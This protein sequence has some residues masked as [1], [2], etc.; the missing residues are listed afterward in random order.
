[1]PPRHP[2]GYMFG[3]LFMATV[4]PILSK[5]P[6]KLLNPAAVVIDASTDYDT[7]AAVSGLQNNNNTKVPL[8][9]PPE[10]GILPFILSLLSMVASVLGDELI[11]IAAIYFLNKGLLPSLMAVRRLSVL[12]G[13]SAIRLCRSLLP[14]GR[15][16]DGDATEETRQFTSPEATAIEEDD[17][18]EWF[19]AEESLPSSEENPDSTPTSPTNEEL[20][21]ELRAEASE[22]DARIATLSKAAETKDD[23]IEDLDQRNSRLMGN[24]RTALDPIGLYTP[25]TDIVVMANDVRSDYNRASKKIERQKKEL[26]EARDRQ[27]NGQL[28]QKDE[29]ISVL[30]NENSRLNS[31]IVGLEEGQRNCVRDVERIDQLAKERVKKLKD[32][33]EAAESTARQAI[34]QRQYGLVR[35]Q[36]SGVV[37]ELRQLKHERENAVHAEERLTTELQAERVKTQELQITAD[38]EA[39]VQQQC[40]DL[41][42]AATGELQLANDKIDNFESEALAKDQQVRDAGEKARAAENQVAENATTVSELKQSLQ[43]SRDQA[44]EWRESNEQL[45]RELQRKEKALERKNRETKSTAA[46]RTSNQNLVA[47]IENLR[48]QLDAAKEE[49]LQNFQSGYL[50]AMS[51]SQPNEQGVDAAD[52]NLANGDQPDGS[53]SVDGELRG[54]I[55]SLIAANND[56][57]LELDS[58]PVQ[59]D[60]ASESRANQLESEKQELLAQL[61]AIEQRPV[62]GSVQAT[63]LEKQ[64]LRQEGYHRA[65]QDCE[66]DA[67]TQIDQ[68]VQ[69][70]MAQKEQALRAPLE[71]KW[72]DRE[73]EW[74]ASLNAAVEK[75]ASEREQGLREQLRISVQR[76]ITAENLVNNPESELNIARE[77]ATTLYTNGK[78]QWR[79]AE[80]EKERADKAVKRAQEAEAEVGRYKQGKAS[81]DKRL[82]EFQDQIRA[83]KRTTPQ[84]PELQAAEMEALE[85]DRI[86]ARA[87]TDEFVHR[88]YDT[89]SRQV[90]FQLINA[91]DKL[92]SL[93]FQLKRP[94]TKPSQLLLLTMLLD[95][96]VDK[97]LCGKLEPLMRQ[98][99]LAQCAAVNAKLMTLKHII[100]ASEE[101]S[102]KE[103]LAELYK[104]RGDEEAEWDLKDP[105]SEPESDEDEEAP[106]AGKPHSAWPRRPLPTGP[107]NRPSQQAEPP[108]APAP[109]DPNLNNPLKRKG[110]LDAVEPEGSGKRR[111]DSDEDLRPVTGPLP[112]T[113]QQG[114]LSPEADDDQNETKL[115]SQDDLPSSDRI[116]EATAPQ[117]QSNDQNHVS[118]QLPG[119]SSF[120]IQHFPLSNPAISSGSPSHIDQALH[121]KPTRIPGPK[122]KA[123]LTPSERQER[124]AIRKYKDNKASSAQE[125]VATSSSTGH[126]GFSFSA[127]KDIASGILPHVR[128]YTRLS[129]TTNTILSRRQHNA[130]T[131][132]P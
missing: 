14:R 64:E 51:Q 116:G 34:S 126:F 54:Q 119:S 43:E 80:G 79:R 127:P 37:E 113:P 61:T 89:P 15:V 24:L 84:Q 111:D 5:V 115:K 62:Q 88:H 12:V 27:E 40:K 85:N 41:L 114:L 118:P 90:L 109:I 63:D 95:A 98:V 110:T 35:D 2:V 69:K 66:R 9:T 74:K 55:E 77:H 70:E 57:Q 93:R 19:N 123:Y 30:T 59:S 68:A 91:N 18:D 120:S 53:A 128:K 45:A 26:K 94:D 46:E 72:N 78:A 101:P 33:T 48:S 52:P 83:L 44:K 71:K 50:N 17:D 73:T 96:E 23:I 31:R 22:K 112:Q 121:P 38:N 132:K 39:E 11:D 25:T 105:E 99:L 104:P 122:P 87:L 29:Q 56:L 92:A 102:K 100:H 32:R 130:S 124:L 3:G 117:Q 47:E 7:I 16:H 36:L 107:R 106:I 97:H 8:T 20:L 28:A 75:E 21:A 86:R 49:A 4:F 1:M 6:S 58:R 65:V 60:L 67:Q 125:A 82:T 13:T 108:V 103:L 81:Q 10:T 42:T 129:G 76:A 131:A